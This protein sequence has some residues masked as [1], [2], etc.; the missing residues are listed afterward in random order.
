MSAAGTGPI[1]I[2]Y[3]GSPDARA[4][5]AR[6][7]DLFAGRAVTVLTVWRSVAATS[8]GAY[9]ALP[10][11]VVGEAVETLDG[12]ARSDA[13]ETAA[14]GAEL[15]RA[16]GLEATPVAAKEDGN[17]WS[18]ILHEARRA[19]AAA[20]VVGARGLSAVKATL[21][22]SVSRALTSHSD[23]PVLVVPGPG[24]PE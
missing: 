18:T 8:K 7:G 19:D 22:G 1:L 17:A 3:D 14:E 21:L 11:A 5:V 24:D 20:I 12:T 15:A 13:E 16:A 6:A 10:A 2:A 9:L 23:R 4:A